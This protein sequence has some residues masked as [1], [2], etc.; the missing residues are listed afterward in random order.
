M[1]AK[2]GE[3]DS[4]TLRVGNLPK[5]KGEQALGVDNWA[6]IV[7]EWAERL[8]VTPEDLSQTNLWG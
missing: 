5:V 2:R 7:T 4:I 6:L 3:M 8:G 1:V